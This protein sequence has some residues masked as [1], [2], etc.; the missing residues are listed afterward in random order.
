LKISPA[1]LRPFK[2][3][4]TD[5]Y[6]SFTVTFKGENVM[7]E[8]GPYRQFF[9]DISRELEPAYNLGLFI[10]SPNN[11]HQSGDHK[12]KW[13]INPKANSTYH[14]SLFEYVGILM[15]CCFRTGG[16]L[17]LDLP[18][19]FWKSITHEEITEQDLEEIDSQL[20]SMIRMLKDCPS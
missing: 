3:K 17:A 20:I 1:F 8:A 19:M 6:L 2:P 4:G 12:S 5:P 15:G 16:H 13:V 9:T 14:F 11:R 18:T 10:P 7:G